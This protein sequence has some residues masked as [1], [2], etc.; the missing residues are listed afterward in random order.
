MGQVKGKAKLSDPTPEASG[1][2]GGSPPPPRQGGTRAPGGEGGGD[3]DDEGEGSGGKQDENRK[4]R[5]DERPA[6]QPEEDGYD[7]ENDEQFNLFSRVMANAL[8]Q[9]TRVPA[10]PPAMFRN[11]KQQDIRMWLMT[12]TDYFG[13]NSWQ[14]EDEAQRIRYAISRMDAKEVAPFALTYR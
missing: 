8:G 12:C 1:A 10:E 2:G 13:Q 4:G 11:E 7:V 14:W 9:R 6:L 3:P 5:R